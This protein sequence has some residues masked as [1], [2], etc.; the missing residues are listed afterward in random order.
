[1]EDN[2]KYS[3]TYQDEGCKFSSSTKILRRSC[4]FYKKYKY[5]LDTIGQPRSNLHVIWTLPEGSEPKIISIMSQQ[6]HL[7]RLNHF[8]SSEDFVAKPEDRS[9]TTLRIKNSQL[10]FRFDGQVLCFT[11]VVKH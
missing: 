9:L 7:D 5:K 3:F 10:Q 4:S 8:T 6:R 1:M 11:N 2:Y